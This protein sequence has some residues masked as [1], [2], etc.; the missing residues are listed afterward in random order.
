VSK[1]ENISDAVS[2]LRGEKNFTKGGKKYIQYR[3]CL[4]EF[5]K[6]GLDGERNMLKGHTLH[7]D[8]KNKGI[9]LSTAFKGIERSESLHKW[10]RRKKPS[11]IQQNGEIWE[12]EGRRVVFSGGKARVDIC[13]TKIEN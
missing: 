9:R 3:Y 10:E 2:M 1:T 7:V 4:T 8:Y 6:G 11:R 12:E 13:S 5:G